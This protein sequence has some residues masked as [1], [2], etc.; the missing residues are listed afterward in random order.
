MSDDVI[1][2]LIADPVRE[3]EE[4]CQ[5]LRE[6]DKAT[7]SG[8]GFEGALVLVDMSPDAK[9][10]EQPTERPPLGERTHYAYTKDTGN[11]LHDVRRLIDCYG[12][13]CTLAAQGYEIDFKRSDDP[14]RPEVVYLRLTG[15][16]DVKHEVSGA[17][18][19]CEAVKALCRWVYEDRVKRSVMRPVEVDEPPAVGDA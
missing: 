12:A 7:D 4:V 13:I 17:S 15:S 9:P 1:E 5:W 8:P 6:H 10:G 18:D 11:R 2:Q 14:W 19:Y 16:D 3:V